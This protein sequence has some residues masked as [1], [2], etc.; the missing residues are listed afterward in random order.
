M[1][2]FNCPDYYRT[3]YRMC[4]SV[5]A[6]VMVHGELGGQ[7]SGVGSLLPLCGFRDQTLASTGSVHLTGLLSL[8]LGD[9]QY[10]NLISHTHT[11]MKSLS[12]MG[13]MLN[14]LRWHER[15]ETEHRLHTIKFFM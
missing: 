4:V 5:P 10:G 14:T 1:L 6:H 3:L 7:L 13:R 8:L 9:R 15:A 11:Q 12:G 2:S